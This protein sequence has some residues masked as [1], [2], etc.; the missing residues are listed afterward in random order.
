MHDQTKLPSKLLS[1][2]ELQEE[3]EHFFHLIKEVQKHGPI[4]LKPYLDLHKLPNEANGWPNLQRIVDKYL[5]VSN[6]MIQDCAA[7]TGPES[8]ATYADESN[9][10]HDSGV[11]F[12]S[13]RRPSVASNLNDRHTNEPLPPFAPAPKTLSKLERITREFKRMRVKPRPEVEEITRVSQKAA[14]EYIPPTTENA[15]RKTL[16]KARSLASLKFGNGSALSLAGRVGS[17]AVPFDAEQMKKH[18]IMYEAS[19][20]KNGRANV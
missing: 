5:R 19:L 1:R 3:R 9:K 20:S 12:G 11:S 6:N 4:I 14:A 8:F 2:D 10:K 17:D 13:E 7:T 18:R 16:K 15:G